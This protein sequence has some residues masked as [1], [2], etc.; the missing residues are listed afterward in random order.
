MKKLLF[1]YCV[2]MCGALYS[3]DGAPSSDEVSY[4]SAVLRSESCSEIYTHEVVSELALSSVNICFS[5]SDSDSSDLDSDEEQQ[6]V[7]L[8]K[9][10]SRFAL[11]DSALFDR[12]QRVQ[13]N[14]EDVEPLP[15]SPGARAILSPGGADCFMCD[16]ELAGKPLFAFP[17]CKESSHLGCVV[18]YVYNN[19]LKKKK[20]YIPCPSCEPNSGSSLTHVALRELGQ[21][22]EKYKVFKSEIDD[23]HFPMPSFKQFWLKSQGL[24]PGIMPEKV[25]KVI[26]ERE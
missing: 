18:R 10:A 26:T 19:F 7:E 2:L 23:H 14:M 5:D 15:A 9:R 13:K 12:Q 1:L 24:Y 25:E 8:K 22:A 17:C 16:N 11:F 4:S 21:K 6:E 3:S 20:R